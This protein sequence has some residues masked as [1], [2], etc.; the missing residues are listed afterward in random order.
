MP[1]RTLTKLGKL[2]PASAKPPFYVSLPVVDDDE[3]GG[4]TSSLATVAG[5]LAYFS[6]A[7]LARLAFCF[8]IFAAF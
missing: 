1:Y 6:L 7:L 8:A 3:G 4:A 2:R 5:G